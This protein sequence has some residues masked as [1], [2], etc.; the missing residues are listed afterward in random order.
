MKKWLWWP[1]GG[2]ILVVLAAAASQKP[3]V[4]PKPTPVG[5]CSSSLLTGY[6]KEAAKEILVTA[7][8]IRSLEKAEIKVNLKNL[9]ENVESVYNMKILRST[10]RRAYI[11]FL[12][13]P[14][15]RGRR[16]LARG[17]Q[18]WSTFPDSKKVVQINR[19]EM[20]GNSAFALADV[21]QMD[22]D[23][24]YD[25]LIVS[26][27]V[28]EKKDMLKLELKAKHEDAPYACVEYWVTKKESF[29]LKARFY[30]VSGKHL[31]TM[32]VESTEKIGGRIRPAISKMVDEVVKGH[33]S[34]WTTKSMVAA[35]VPDAVFTQEYLQKQQ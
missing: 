14:E 33:I 26:E 4:S 23:E 17:Q 2:I 1:I 34:W 35:Q 25:P 12:S 22:A 11:E 30:S 5:P 29:P 20:I 3:T 31:K 16:M 27:E 6:T 19:R 7:E 32:T 15:E 9:S 24:D 13:P 28:I 8:K 18:Y 10:D 21:F